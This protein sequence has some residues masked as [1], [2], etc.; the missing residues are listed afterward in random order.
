MQGT[1][2]VNHSVDGPIAHI[3]GIIYLTLTLHFIDR[4]TDYMHRLDHKWKELSN[5]KKEDV[6]NVHFVNNTL[7]NN[8]LPFHVGKFRYS[9]SGSVFIVLLTIFSTELYWR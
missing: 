7:L 6:Q 1:E 4:Q 2:S 3:V 8:I 9:L 5:E